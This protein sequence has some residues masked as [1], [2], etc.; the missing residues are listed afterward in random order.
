[1]KTPEPTRIKSPTFLK[2]LP[3]S[4]LLLSGCQTEHDPKAWA[5]Y[6]ES[7]KRLNAIGDEWQRK[8]DEHNQRIY[9][10]HHARKIQQGN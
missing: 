2:L 9:Y 5:R 3:F 4:I 6:Q 1:M 8:T 10:Q 7:M